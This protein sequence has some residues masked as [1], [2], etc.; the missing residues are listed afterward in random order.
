MH[1]V[2]LS[3]YFMYFSI[4]ENLN[5]ARRK[6]TYPAGNSRASTTRYPSRTLREPEGPLL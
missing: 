1:V 6:G 3:I 5:L 2:F 4:Y